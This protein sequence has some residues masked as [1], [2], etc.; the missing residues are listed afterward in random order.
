MVS[1]ADLD[2]VPL[3]SKRMEA[4]AVAAH[5]FGHRLPT[6][7]RTASHDRYL[8]VQ[9][10]QSIAVRRCTQR[11]TPRFHGIKSSCAKDSALVLTSPLPI[12]VTNSRIP[13]PASSTVFWPAM[14]GPASKSMMAAMRCARAELVAIFTTGAIGFPVGVPNPIVSTP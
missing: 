1:A 13:S 4:G 8:A 14:I 7:A 11:E 3:E 2:G 9:P 5:Y 12:L 10:E 6:A